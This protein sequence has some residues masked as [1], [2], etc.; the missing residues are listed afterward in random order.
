[1]LRRATIIVSAQT[2]RRP[3]A[4]VFLGDELSA[5]LDAIEK[6]APYQRKDGAKL[7]VHVLPKFTRDTTDRNRTSP[8]RFTGKFEFRMLGSSNSIACANIMLN[9]AVADVLIG[10]RGRTRKAKTSRPL[11]TISSESRLSITSA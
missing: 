2:K 10:V 8:S 7:G 11:F 3:V 9:A 1:M 5:V 6:D 4:S